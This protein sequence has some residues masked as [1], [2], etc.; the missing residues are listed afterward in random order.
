[1]S[2]HMSVLVAG[3]VILSSGLVPSSGGAQAG[4]L[5]AAVSGLVPIPVGPLINNRSV[6]VGATVAL[7]YSPETV[8]W[9]GIR[10]E[11]SG[12]P[13]SSHD[14]GGD[15]NVIGKVE[16]GSSTLFATA[17]P[18]FDIP[19]GSGH[20]YTTATGGVA[21]LW[22]SSVRRFDGGPE[23]PLSAV[24]S[25]RATNF[26][27]SGGGGFVMPLSSPLS[28]DIGVRYYDLGGVTYTTPFVNT[29]LP[30][31]HPPLLPPPTVRRHQATMFAPSIGLTWRL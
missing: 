17:G 25:G 20:F 2:L 8:S 24:A 4:P 3:A 13:S 31:P 15:P 14:P 27:W 1:M 28:A 30:T 12:L 16:N 5:S 11:L 26:V 23:G 6:G 21:R 7:R 10:F 29:S 18:E 19:V 9:L 22:E